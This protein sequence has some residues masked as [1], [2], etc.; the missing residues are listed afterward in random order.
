MSSSTSSLTRTRERRHEPP[1]SEWDPYNSET[2]RQ[3]ATIVET[4]T[5]PQPNRAPSIDDGAKVS[6]CA[7]IA[8]SRQ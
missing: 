7:D 6:T 4:V 2:A 1:R 5:E 3:M 8:N